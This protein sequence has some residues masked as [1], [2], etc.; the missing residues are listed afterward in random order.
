MG[1]NHRTRL[2]LCNMLTEMI[3]Y[4]PNNRL[5]IADFGAPRET[6]LYDEWEKPARSGKEHERVQWTTGL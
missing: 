2:V 5:V 6:R 4:P 3:L 1:L